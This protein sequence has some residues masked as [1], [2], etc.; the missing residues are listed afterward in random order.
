MT[1]FW[2]R[3]VTAIGKATIE[4]VFDR[5]CVFSVCYEELRW[6]DMRTGVAA[7]QTAVSDGGVAFYFVLSGAFECNG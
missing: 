4:V 3:S 5:S 2:V 6:V 7:Y 1:R